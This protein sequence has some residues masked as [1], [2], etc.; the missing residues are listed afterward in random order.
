MVSTG[1]RSSFLGLTSGSQ[2]FLP[3]VLRDFVDYRDRLGDLEKGYLLVIITIEPVPFS[4]PRTFSDS[5][6]EIPGLYTSVF[7]TLDR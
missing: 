6:S 4:L 5:F 2:S 1:R 7:P 3:S